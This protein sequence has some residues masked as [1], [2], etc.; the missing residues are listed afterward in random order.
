MNRAAGKEFNLLENLLI[1]ARCQ[2]GRIDYLP[3]ELDLNKIIREVVLLFALNAANKG[4][5]IVMNIPV[6]TQV[7]ADFNML[8]TILRNLIGNSVKYTNKGGKIIIESELLK[9]FLQVEITDNGI[10]MSDEI[11]ASLFKIDSQG[12][13]EGTA[14]ERGSGMGLLLVKEFVNING[15]TVNVESAPDKGSSFVFTL[16]RSQ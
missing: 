15:G 9:D 4:I 14:G 16:K 8:N 1:W 12:T 2:T 5:E 7:F 3:V 11:K 10:G 6:N 13:T